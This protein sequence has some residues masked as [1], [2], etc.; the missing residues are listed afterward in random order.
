MAIRVPAGQRNRLER[1]SR[2]VLRSAI[3]EKRLSLT[4]RGR[5]RYAF[6]SREF[7]LET[8]AEW[9][10]GSSAIEMS[11]MTFL[12]RLAALIPA[13]HV[14]LVTYH[15]L[16]APAASYRDRVVPTTEEEA[17]E[18]CVKHQGTRASDGRGIGMP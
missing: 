9:R 14:N 18:S 6:K 5:V 4:S 8:G 16:L 11:M 2:Y 17:G 12:S 15:G 13:P 10:D 3:D 1:L 7:P